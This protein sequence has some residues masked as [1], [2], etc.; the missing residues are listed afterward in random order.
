MTNPFF[1]IITCTYNSEKYLAECLASV[2]SQDFD[3]YEHIIIDGYSTDKTKTIINSY[4]KSNAKVKQ[5]SATPR[6]IAQAMNHGISKATGEYL[7]FLHSDDLLST[8]DTLKNVKTLLKKLNNPDWVYGQIEVIDKDGL[9]KGVFPRQ[10]L[11]QQARP[12][13]LK[14]INYVPHQATLVKKDVFSRYGVFNPRYKTVMDYDLW[15]RI[16]PHTNYHYLPLIVSRYR[17]HSSARSSSRANLSS[18]MLELKE[19]RKHHLSKLG[20]FLAQ[21]VDILLLKVNKTLQ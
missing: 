20:S 7:L 19:L 15:L 2:K 10:K 11:L 1:T 12:S 14:L 8:P 4:K 16:A 9:S 17:I 13:L 5:F 21:L 3:D 18:T 6:G